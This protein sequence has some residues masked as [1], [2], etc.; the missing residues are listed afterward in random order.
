METVAVI[1][2]RWLTDVDGGWPKK[3][4]ES[5]NEGCGASHRLVA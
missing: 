2:R 3:A 5:R 4:F 1:G